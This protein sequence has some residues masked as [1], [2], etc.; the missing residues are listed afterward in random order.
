MAIFRM[1]IRQNLNNEC[2][3][4][5]RKSGMQLIQRDDLSINAKKVISLQ[6]EFFFEYEISHEEAYLLTGIKELNP[7]LQYF[8]N[9]VTLFS[10]VK[11]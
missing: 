4:I 11:K 10:G 5:L 1:L 8:K 6:K 3:I 9:Q 7:V 2:Y